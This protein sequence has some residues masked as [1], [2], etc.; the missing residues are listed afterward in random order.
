MPPAQN[1]ANPSSPWPVVSIVVGAILVLIG[2]FLAGSY[3]F[4]AVIERIGEPDQSL[5]FWYLPLLLVGIMALIMGAAL[6]VIGILRLRGNT[7][8]RS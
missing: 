7:R 2:L 1:A 8:R 5:L 4:S 3:V 6:G